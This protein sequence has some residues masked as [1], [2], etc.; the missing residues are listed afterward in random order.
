MF[1]IAGFKAA[2]TPTLFDA[3]LL[4][5]FFSLVPFD[6]CENSTRTQILTKQMYRSLPT[7]AGLSRV[8]WIWIFFQVNSLIAPNEGDQH[9][10]MFICLF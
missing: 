4:I 8:K 3:D 1:L 5:F 7:I 2:I 9:Q 6:K 10:N